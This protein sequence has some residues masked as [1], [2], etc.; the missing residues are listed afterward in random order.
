MATIH[1]RYKQTDRQKINVLIYVYRAVKIN[2]YLRKLT[3]KSCVHG[4]IIL[5]CSV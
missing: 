4:Y 5:T 2:P 3:Q 1:Q